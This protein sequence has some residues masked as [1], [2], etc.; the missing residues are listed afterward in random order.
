[1]A[2][3]GAL[4][5]PIRGWL[6]QWPSS[7]TLPVLATGVFVTARLF[8]ALRRERAGR[9]GRGFGEGIWSGHV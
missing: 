5:E 6:L 1:M 3:L 8:Y 4:I 7:V 2:E 9:Q